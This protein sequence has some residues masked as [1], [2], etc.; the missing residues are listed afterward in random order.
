MK[1]F[2]ALSLLAGGMAFAQSGLMGGTSGI[3]QHNAYTLGQWGIEVGTGGDIALDSWALSRGGVVT[4]DGEKGVISEWAGS[5]A[6]NL[7]GAIGLSDFLD[8]GMS[9]PLYYDHTNTK[10]M[11]PM[12]MMKA[13]RGDVNLWMKINPVGDEST[14]FALATVID[15]Y[16]PTGDVSVG[17]RPRHAWFLSDNGGLTN[18]YTSADL[19]IGAT[20]VFTLN[21]TNKGV[22]LIWNTNVGIVYADEGSSTLTYGTGLNFVATDWLEAFVEYSGEFRIEGDYYERNIMEDPMRLTPGLRFHLPWNLEFSAGLD[23][24]VRALKNFTF[25]Y[26]KEMETADKYQIHYQDSKNKDVRYGYVPTP[27]Y[28]GTAT[29]TWRFGGKLDKDT[30]KDGVKDELDKCDHSP[31]GAVVDSTGCPI[32]SDKD[33]L[34][35]GLDKCANTP[36]GAIIDTTGCPMDS[37]KDGVYDGIDK[38]DNTP[39]GVPVDQDG[40]VADFDKDGVPDGLDKCPNSLQ[41]AVVDSTGCVA[42]ADKDGIADSQDKC[43]DTPN[44]AVV[45]SV[46]CPVDSD[47]DGVADGIDL[48]ANTREGAKV[49][50]HGCDDDFDADGVPNAQDKC[51]NTKQGV[52]VD[53]TGCALDGDK[54]GVP[55]GLDKCP[56][57]AEGTAVDETGCALDFDKDGVPDAQDKC[58]NTVSGLAVDSTGCALD[59]DKDGVPDGYDKCPN[60][61]KD[62]PVDSTGCFLDTD[63]DGVPDYEDKCPNTVAGVK[64]DKKG[65]PVN[66]KED[67]DQLKKGIAF[68]TN[69][70]KLTKPS[71]ATLDDIVRLMNKIPDA[72]LEVQGHTDNTGSA[73]T[74]KKLSQDRAETVVNYFISKGIAAER[75]RAVG[76]GPEKPIADNKSKQGRAKNRRVEL[77]PFFD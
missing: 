55:D 37:D 42:D 45:D 34:F 26:K 13:S 62:A 61:P 57:T 64:I 39:A 6:G 15:L 47:K 16:L 49:D 44:G 1:K 12:D 54:D 66:K 7:N 35:D 5:I 10:G 32:D 31:E 18:P 27:N 52:K 19:N 22:P 65:C 63:R 29:L 48:C 56:N 73:E 25:D 8:I 71:Y 53:S 28:A 2:V 46:G 33:G 58:P 40:C 76:Y 69:S 23:V 59:E 9:L 38:C 70:A 41:G 72:K 21:F 4:R 50:E 30:D 67:P 11:D 43:A 77:V 51:P 60:T 3:H 68:Q 20:L 36:K 74:N 75:V 14:V 17:M 24:A